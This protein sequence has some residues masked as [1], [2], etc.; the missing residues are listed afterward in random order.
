MR[1]DECMYRELNWVE[2]AVQSCGLVVCLDML[3]VLT[4]THARV[5]R[6]RFDFVE[7]MACRGGCIG[8]ECERRARK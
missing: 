5:R 6:R 4:R 7:V 1:V 8:G 3:C 2:N